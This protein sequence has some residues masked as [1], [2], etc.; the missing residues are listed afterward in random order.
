MD[1]IEKRWNSFRTQVISA[2]APPIQVREMRLA[3]YGG[4]KAMLDANL[5]MAELPEHVGVAALQLYYAEVA[6]FPAKAF[7]ENINGEKGK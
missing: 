3:F 7:K 1:T 4:V 5:E 2:D 6:A